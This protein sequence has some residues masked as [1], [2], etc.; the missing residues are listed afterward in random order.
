M[1]AI[2]TTTQGNTTSLS[3]TA[4]DTF[5]SDFSNMHRTTNGLFVKQT[6]SDKPEWKT[7]KTFS[8]NFCSNPNSFKNV[9]RKLSYNFTEIEKV[10]QSIY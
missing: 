2:E 7:S 5:T 3:N 10:Y 6:T 4:S 1:T 9:F 8:C